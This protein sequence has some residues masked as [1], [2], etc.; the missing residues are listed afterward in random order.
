MHDNRRGL[1]QAPG[2]QIHVAHVEYCGSLSDEE[3]VR[4][5]SVHVDVVVGEKPVHVRVTHVFAVEVVHRDL[6]VVLED[7]A[8]DHL[9][10]DVQ[11]LSRAVLLH[12]LSHR[13]DLAGALVSEG[14]RNQ[15]E[16]ISLELM[17]V[18]AADAAALDLHQDVPVA[19]GRNGI[20]LYVK[21]LEAGKN[22]DMGGFRHGAS[23]ASSC[24]CVR[25]GSSLHAVQHFPDDCFN[26]LLVHCNTSHYLMQSPSDI[27]QRLLL[28]KVLALVSPSPV[29][30]AMVKVQML[31]PPNPSAA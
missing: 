31:S 20:F 3:I 5:P 18:G 21:V 25:A 17:R 15:S 4:E 13:D 22:G 23:L 1:N 30:L 28:V 27:T 6:R 12:V 2:V 10:P 16:G 29:L 14:D 19:K 9:V 11:V 7:H 26:T 8:G 24:R